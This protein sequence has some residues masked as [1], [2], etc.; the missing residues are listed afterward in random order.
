MK[1][2]RR[3]IIGWI[4][5]FILLESGT[6]AV[7][8][9]QPAAQQRGSGMMASERAAHTATLLSDGRVL[10]AGG[11]RTVGRSQRREYLS[12]TE[13]YNPRTGKCTAGADMSY[14]RSGH[15]AMLLDDGSVLVAG[16]FGP[17]GPLSS[18]EL[19][20]PSTGKFTVISAM[21]ARRIGCAAA[22][23]RDGRILI[24]GG[25][26]DDREPTTS[27]EVFDMKT[28]TFSRTGHMHIPRSFASCT[29]LP[30]GFIL[31]AGGSSRRDFPLASAEIYDP[32]DGSFRET[33]SMLEGRTKHASAM[34]AGGDIYLFGGMDD[35]DWKAVYST[36]ERYSPSTGTFLAC[37]PLRF[38]RS[39]MSNAVVVLNDGTVFLGG[40]SAVSERYFPAR[41]TSVDAVK[42]GAACYYSTATLLADGSV[43][44]AGGYDEKIRTSAKLRRWKP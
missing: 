44:L 21:T 12:S 23:L 3:A 13:I 32:S 26:S 17:S 19:F 42:V 24:A 34:V 14:P 6:L 7:P 27:A 1:A 41:G 16:G 2:A 10:L 15:I 5:L 33:G 25:G 4:S 31:V 29:P 11:F 35:R 36:V 20:I 38:P 39:M 40:G 37:A 8:A 43:L 18:A 30:S 22:R 28:R 9:G